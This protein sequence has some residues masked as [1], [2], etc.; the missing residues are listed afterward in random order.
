[1]IEVKNIKKSFGD[2]QILK[3]ISTTFEAGKTNL[4]IGRSG[5]GK[6]VMLKTLLGIHTPDEGSISFDGRI[7]S[8][9]SK[10][11][12]REL[13]T[14]IGMVFQ[15]SALF[16]SMT[17]EENVG[18][19]LKMFSNKKKNEIR[20]RVNQVLERVN[21]V[22]ANKKF[23]S[24]ISGGM[25]KRVA[26]ARAIVNN[27]KYLFCDEPNSGLDPETSILIDVLIQ[28]ITKEY[29]MTT[30]INTHDMNSVLQIGEKIVFLKN[31]MKEWEGNNEQIL[32]TKNKSIVEFVYSS[33]LFKKVRESLLADAEEE[34][35][36]K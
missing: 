11:E 35:E 5:S 14:E 17:V 26:I 25:Q 7:Y 19:P 27:P 6:T 28:E 15:G 22:D 18:F 21:L 12:K 30:V 10:D 29:N 24:E 3:G 16:D 13:R 33:D 31:G 1:M 34:D 9:L 8:E 20:D 4:I 36:K 32:E 2:S 23:P